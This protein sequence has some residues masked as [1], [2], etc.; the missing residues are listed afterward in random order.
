[1]KYTAPPTGVEDQQ[2]GDALQHRKRRSPYGNMPVPLKAQKGHLYLPRQSK[3]VFYESKIEHDCLWLLSYDQE[4]IH[5]E[6]AAPVTYHTAD[7]KSHTY[8]P[9]FDIKRRLGTG[10]ELQQTLECKPHDLVLDIISDEPLAWA[11]CADIIRARGSE[12]LVV[13]DLDLTPVW[14]EHA[15]RFG[16]YQM[17]PTEP[18]FESLILKSLVRGPLAFQTLRARVMAQLSAQTLVDRLLLRLDSTLSS[19][20]ARGT[21][22]ADTGVKPDQHCT[23]GLPGQIHAEPLRVRGVTATHLVRQ[24]YASDHQPDR[25]ALADEHADGVRVSAI[26]L[27]SKLLATPKGKAFQK[28]FSL[29]SDP[30]VKLDAA[31][32]QLL[33][34]A[35]GLPRRTIFRFQTKLQ[36]AGAPAITFSDLVPHLDSQRQQLTR[37]LDEDVQLIVATIINTKYLVP[38]G[39]VG[40]CLGE[41]NLHKMVSEACEVIGKKPPALSTIQRQLQT[42]RDSDPVAFETRRNGADAGHK[43]DARLGEYPVLLYGELLAIDCTPADVFMTVDSAELRPRKGRGAKSSGQTRPNAIRANVVQIIEVATRQVL[44]SRIHKRGITAALVLRDL[45]AVLL[46]NYEH[47]A[48]RGVTHLPTFAGLPRALRLDRGLEFANQE[49]A[50]VVESLG[51][52][53]I[54]R[55]KSSRHHGGVEERAIGTV[56]SSHHILPG[57]TMSNIGARQGYR[58]PQGAKLDFDTLDTYHQRMVEV[59]NLRPAPQQAISRNEHASKLIADG[60]VALRVPS[61][62]ELQYIQER[63]LP[64]RPRQCGRN[65]INILNLTYSSQDA[66]FRA[67]VIQ[68]REVEVVFNPADISTI[69]VVHP[70]SGLLIPVVPKFPEGVQTPISL[71]EWEGL[72]SRLYQARKAIAQGLPSPQKVLEQALAERAA[73]MAHPKGRRAAGTKNKLLAAKRAAGPAPEE[74]TYTDDGPVAEIVPFY[75]SKESV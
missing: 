26:H 38:V 3:T 68:R 2:T 61:A 52:Q 4:V 33:E 7:G 9:D 10:Q 34:T 16:S 74:E 28:L 54:R 59:Y 37:Q 15:K 40:R 36:W 41:A 8:T 49:I 6:R 65:G 75:T 45:Q 23:I 55:N 22:I 27:E 20:I 17:T 21:V 29:Y 51:I 69:H 32:I 14:V 24:V 60:A 66:A 11:A 70:D 39:T 62:G 19:L 35:T 47:A 25:Q 53:V 63:M 48:S 44:S 43:L 73:A 71:T 64:Q 50:R 31:R 72:H 46:G 13:T 56:V 30:S 12:L 5:V 18:E 42:I 1:M 57:T 67:L 58:A